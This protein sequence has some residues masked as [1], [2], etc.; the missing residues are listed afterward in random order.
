[1]TSNLSNDNL[2][3]I[4]SEA[5]KN[6]DKSPLQAVVNALEENIIK[7]AIQQVKNSI[8]VVVDMQND[9]IDGALGSPE[10]QAIVK[11]VAKYIKDF[12]GRYI[13]VTKDQHVE[14]F[15]NEYI[16]GQK[17]PIHCIT[18]KKG[19][20]LEDSIQEALTEKKQKGTF[21]N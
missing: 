16:E 3:T 18:G 6:N 17:I 5:V 15:Y 1:M 10:A 20:Q 19:S 14:D 4:Y 2:F 12:Q 13:Y 8:L 21:I 11:P 7:E 9:F